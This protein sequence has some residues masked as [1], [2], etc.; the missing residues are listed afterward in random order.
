MIAGLSAGPHAASNSFGS[1]YVSLR[2]MMAQAI[3]AIL[4]ASRYRGHFGWPAANEAGEPGPLGAVL[5][6]VSND[7]HGTGDQQPPQI[8]I[9]L[10]G[11]AAEPLLAASRML[12]RHQAD[13]GGKVASRAKRLPVADLGDQR[14]GHNRTNAG[15]LL[16]PAAVFTGAVPG[17]NAFVDNAD[18]SGD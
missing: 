10:L 4:L 5:A 18:L 7:G 13:P 15:D 14:G 11:D 1:L 12:L 2:T 9:A 8:A 16:E 17:L 6:C 3:R